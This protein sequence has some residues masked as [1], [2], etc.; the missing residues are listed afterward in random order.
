MAKSNNSESLGSRV[1]LRN[2]FL[3]ALHV[4]VV[5]VSLWV[6]P[7]LGEPANRALPYAAR[8]PARNLV[9]SS[10]RGAAILVLISGPSNTFKYRSRRQS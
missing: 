6:H 4:G 5:V 1:D 10:Y 3:L 2:L 8:P 7:V 9:V